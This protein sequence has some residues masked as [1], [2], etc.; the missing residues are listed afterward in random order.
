MTK[1]LYQVMHQAKKVKTDTYISE[2][3]DLMTSSELNQNHPLIND[4]VVFS[5]EHIKFTLIQLQNAVYDH[6]KEVWLVEKHDCVVNVSL[7]N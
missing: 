3:F 6:I 7:F 2:K 4:R 5:N 1:T